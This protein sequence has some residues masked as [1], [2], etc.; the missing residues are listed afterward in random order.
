MRDVGFNIGE[1]LGRRWIATMAN[2]ASRSKIEIGHQSC[3]IK[4]TIL[5]M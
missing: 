4:Q 5:A 2:T 1:L 3:A